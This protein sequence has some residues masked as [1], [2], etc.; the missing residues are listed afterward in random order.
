MPK[1]QSMPQSMQSLANTQT[2]PT[3]TTVAVLSLIFPQSG[4]PIGAMFVTLEIAAFKSSH[5]LVV[6]ETD[7]KKDIAKVIARLCRC[8]SSDLT[9]ECDRAFELSVKEAGLQDGDEVNLRHPFKSGTA[10]YQRLQRLMLKGFE[11]H[12]QKLLFQDVKTHMT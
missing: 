4:Q 5:S 9:L 10:T 2:S 1:S 7:T 11:S 8:N 6:L 3:L 12:N